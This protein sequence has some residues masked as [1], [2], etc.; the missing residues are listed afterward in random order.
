MPCYFKNKI[1]YLRRLFINSGEI[2][3]GKTKKNAGFGITENK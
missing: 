2:Y 3:Y 1:K